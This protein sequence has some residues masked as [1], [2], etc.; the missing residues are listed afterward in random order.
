MCTGCKDAGT[1]CAH[2]GTEALAAGAGD[3]DMSRDFQKAKPGVLR[4][5]VASAKQPE[6]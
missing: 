3:R 1:K 4:D 6:T 2:W 5:S